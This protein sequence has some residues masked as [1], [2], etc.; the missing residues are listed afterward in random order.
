VLPS[1]ISRTSKTEIRL[2]YTDRNTEANEEAKRPHATFSEAVTVQPR[3][4]EGTLSSDF[5][6]R[7]TLSPCTLNLLQRRPW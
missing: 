1:T 4:C 7:C 3:G 2:E 5:E 6:H